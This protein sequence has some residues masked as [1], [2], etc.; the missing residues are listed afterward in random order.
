MSNHTWTCLHGV[1]FGQGCSDRCLDCENLDRDIKALGDKNSDW[2]L[3]DRINA[4]IRRVEAL[5]RQAAGTL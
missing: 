5:E 4:L 3:N 2:F 1:E